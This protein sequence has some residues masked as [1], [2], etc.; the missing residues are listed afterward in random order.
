MWKRLELEFS[1]TWKLLIREIDPLRVS[2]QGKQGILNMYMRYNPA[3][4]EL[5]QRMNNF[6]TGRKYRMRP[7]YT[8]YASQLPSFSLSISSFHLVADAFR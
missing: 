4:T 5:E 6:S 3:T 8:G 2:Q 1:N 7:V